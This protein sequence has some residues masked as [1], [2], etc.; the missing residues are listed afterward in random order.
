MLDDLLAG[1]L[2]LASFLMWL[3]GVVIAI[4]VHEFA[5]A[6]G[7]KVAGDPT[8]VREGRVTLN[9]LAHLDPIGTLMLLV[10]G[11][12]WGRPVNTDPAYFR[13]GRWDKLMVSLWGPLANIITAAIFAMP[14]RLGIAAH[15]EALLGAVVMINL[16]LAFFNLLPIAPLDGS[17]ILESLL[18]PRQALSYRFFM[19]RYGILLLLAIIVTPIGKFLFWVPAQLLFALMTGLPV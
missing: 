11:L 14:L 15:R 16:L 7:A 18:P 13:R 17:H 10:F 5:H 4:T 19:H 3:I 6:W 9:P 1:R 8:P 2:T 12:G